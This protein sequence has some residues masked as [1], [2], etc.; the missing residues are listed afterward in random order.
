[1]RV[2]FDA[3]R[4]Q[5]SPLTGVGRW[6][7]NLVPLLRSS[8]EL[9][10][11]TDA[12]RPSPGIEGLEEVRLSMPG[13]EP[14]WL[15]VAVARWLRNFDGIFHGTYNAI[16]VF[17]PCPSVV[18]IY[19]LAWEDHPE[20]LGPAQRYAFMGQARNSARHAAAVITIS[21]FT[22]DAIIASYGVPPERVV[23]APPA[24]DPLFGPGRADGLAALRPLL[25]LPERYIV[26][27]GGANRRGAKVAVEAW[28]RLGPD[29]LPLVVV[30]QPE[31][32]VEGAVATGRLSDEDWASVL[33][34][35]EAFCY[36]TRYEG[37][38]MPATEA[39]ASGTPVV[40]AR[41]GPLPEVLG[42]A[43]EWCETASVDDIATGLARLMGDE[44][45]RFELRAAGLARMAAAPGWEESAA[46]VLTAY[47]LAS[48]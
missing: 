25:G 14:F 36:P 24:V 4:L 45:R 8:V 6:L 3:R 22:R 46:S 9:V 39:A 12:R 48:S 2:A 11:L 47:E 37:W 33:A 20:D 29:K 28:Q 27:L 18:N 30:G 13:R 10:L 43:A 31:L 1:M 16:P 15:Q 44:L 23:L 17:T 19:D 34:G 5:D 35:A 42:P 26:A 41:L 32:A 40:C 7:T 21:K 38:G